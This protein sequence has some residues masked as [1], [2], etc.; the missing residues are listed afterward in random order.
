MSLPRAVSNCVAV[1]A[2]WMSSSSRLCGFGP[3]PPE[4][5]TRHT[6]NGSMQT[7]KRRRNL[8]SLCQRPRDYE[9]ER[10][11]VPMWTE[12]PFCSIEL[13]T[14]KELPKDWL[15]GVYLGR[16][17]LTLYAR[18]PNE[19]AAIGDRTV[20]ADE[21]NELARYRVR[22]VS[23]SIAGLDNNVRSKKRNQGC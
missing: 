9:R 14:F 3:S 20:T 5:A 17:S 16:A 15:T 21:C 11:D 23:E 12:G 8:E 18:L 4:Y 19:S 7:G 1:R 2:A 22:Y 6:R 10:G 13:V